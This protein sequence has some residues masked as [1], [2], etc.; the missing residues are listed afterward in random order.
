ME[1]QNVPSGGQAAS[2]PVVEQSNTA[3]KGS[4]NTN[5]N[6][7]T[8]E[9]QALKGGDV[10]SF[11]DIESLSTPQ[12]KDADTTPVNGKKNEP[13]TQE[14]KNKELADDLKDAG[15]E[16]EKQAA[17]RKFKGKYGDKTLEIAA[18]AMF[19]IG[20]EGEEKE[21]R[22]ED[23]A[24]DYIGQQEIS[25]R[26]SNLDTIKRQ[27]D[28]DT[29]QFNM[30]LDNI[31][32]YIENESD[33]LGL[34]NYLIELSGGD[35]VSYQERLFEALAPKIAEWEAMGD[36]E[37]EAF[38][39]RRENELLKSQSQKRAEADAQTKDL[40]EIAQQV[41]QI[42][43]EHGL[44]QQQFYD[45]YHEIVKAGADPD[46]L[47]PQDVAEYLNDK[48]IAEVIVDYITKKNPNFDGADR[49]AIELLGEIE[50][51]ASLEPADVFAAIDEIVADKTEA[52]VNEKIR[53]SK[54]GKK[55]ETEINPATTPL[56]WDDV[57]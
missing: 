13:K 27:L 17:I 56:D 5:T 45:A 48:Q 30:L 1:P 21:V 25:R 37:K 2:A 47:E 22:F 33:P 29:G 14:A 19:K 12:K 43:E 46:A 8:A 52:I 53:S 4:I 41:E 35:P 24:N 49:L 10:L 11:D 26:F 44:S 34:V 9:P 15:T 23:L 32:K 36:E 51:N 16:A 42:R 55:K 39:L 18:D 40:S 28:T 20:K 54:S 38:R 7:N 3:P 6:T 57:L 50:A 31:N